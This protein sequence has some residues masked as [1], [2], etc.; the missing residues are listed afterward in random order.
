M[1][2]SI[3]ILLFVFLVRFSTAQIPDGYYSDAEG[4]TGDTLKTVLHNIISGHTEL[5]YDAVKEA[6]KD[7]DEDTTDSANVICLYSGWSYAKTEFGNGSEQWNREHVWSKSHGDFGDDPPAGTDL[8]HLRPA[9]A[10]VNSAKSNRDF[11]YGTTQYIDGS[12]V[13]DC[14]YS[15]DIWE[16][17]D[18]V[19]GDVARMIFYM[20]TRYEG[21]GSE[22]DLEIVDYVNTAPS[23]EPLYGKLTT[24][25]AWNTLDPVDDWERNR[26]DIIYYNYQNNRNPFIDHPEYVNAIWGGV[27][28]EPSNHVASFG[29]SD[30]STTTVTLT[31]DD[32]DGS[33]P[34]ENYLLKINTSG[35]F[36]APADGVP[37][38]TD[39]D[40]TD[41]EGQVNVS[42]GTET[43]TWTDLTPD[44]TYY[45]IIYPYTNLGDNTD[46]KTSA[47][48]PADS[49]NTALPGDS[50]LISE[51]AD[52]SDV[53]NAKFI[54]LYNHGSTAI[55]FD[56][57][58][59]YISR[60]ANGSSWADVRLT[61]T[62]G[63]GETYVIS[64]RVSDFSSA[65]GFDAELNSGVISGNGNDSYYLFKGGNHTT[66]TLIDAF[67]EIDVDGSG[68]TWEYS[69][70]KAVRVF[71]VGK[72]NPVWTADEWHINTSATTAEMTPDWYHK[73][74]TWTGST[75]SDWSNSSNWNDGGSGSL[76]APD[77]GCQ[78]IIEN[79]SN[80]PEI[81][82]E[83]SCNS[84]LIK[85]NAEITVR[86]GSRFFVS[87]TGQ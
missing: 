26:N 81:T 42:H 69:N 73:T 46:Y 25:L 36:T 49:A 39:T 45:F 13:T 72:P 40:L 8:H 48:V 12:G 7:T 28:D 35:N 27:E 87:G 54:E 50:L 20:A 38:Y 23:N 55:D 53:A 17:R 76:F 51:I 70:S 33:V 79:T 52:P 10:S 85:C 18:E 80:N 9:D 15:I 75:S 71:S 24:L 82:S 43:Y 63:A 5:S 4:L 31:W 86:N 83:S 84:I 66:G 56:T 29:V 16:P 1:K 47:P 14:Y 34:A 30:S 11:D 58:T 41:G 57:E 6:L 22:P 2:F 74:L 19:K 65:Y 67:G 61:G 77:A 3:S 21:D 37:E 68:Q 44:N 59:W 60:Q 64:Y 32:N 78:I 62:I